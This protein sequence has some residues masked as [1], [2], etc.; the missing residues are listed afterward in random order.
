MSG[1]E[2]LKGFSVFSAT[3][4]EK[5]LEI[6]RLGDVMTFSAGEIICQEGDAAQNLYG[7]LDGEVEL[8]LIVRDKILRADIQYEEAIQRHFETHE[9]DIV[10]DTVEPG[11]VFGW[12]ALIKPNV[13][14]S[15]ARCSKPTRILSLPATDLAALFRRDYEV[16][17][18]F[19]EKLAEIISQRLK[20]RTDK[21]IESWSEAFKATRI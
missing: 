9:R 10:V 17:F 1:N 19:M 16:G 11:E 15:T 12:S 13:L 18:I 8:S 4:D 2:L 21:L 6:A 5:Q 3:S 20:N 14:T 7:V